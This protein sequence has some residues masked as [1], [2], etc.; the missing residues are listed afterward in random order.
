MF[1]SLAPL[2]DRREHKKEDMLRDIEIMAP[3][4]LLIFCEPLREWS[5]PLGRLRG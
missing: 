2:I 3:P 4:Y 5:R 1:P